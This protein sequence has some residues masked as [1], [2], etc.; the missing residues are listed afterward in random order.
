MAQA[1]NLYGNLM[2]LINIPNGE[3]VRTCCGEGHI[4][5]EVKVRT[6]YLRIRT[7]VDPATQAPLLDSAVAYEIQRFGIDMMPLD[8]DYPA[9]RPIA[10]D[11]LQVLMAA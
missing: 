7:V 9:Y 5:A 10:T 3:W 11:E 8:A 4:V 2:N 1:A 6:G